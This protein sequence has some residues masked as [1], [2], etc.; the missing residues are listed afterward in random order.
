MLYRFLQ[1][2]F[3]IVFKI[4]FRVEVHN[5]ELIPDETKKLII[6]GNHTSNLDPIIMSAF[7]DRKINWM[8]KKELFNNKILAYFLKKLG[9]FPVDRHK[10]DLKA[11]KTALNIL[12]KDEVL[13]IFP[14]GTRVKEKNYD[15]IKAGVAL[16]AQ[17]TESEVLPFYI[18]GNFKIFRK[19]NIYY[20]E[21][22][23]IKKE[24]KYSNEELEEISQ[25]IM[26]LV[27]GDE[28]KWK[29]Y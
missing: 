19:I 7:F 28:I 26:R 4:I 8:G 9:V 18:D 17:R 20:R 16:I 6:C 29:L 21:P 5:K 23:K 22:I 24:I 11:V 14:E 1:V 15:S 13:G 27:Y 10:N 2:L 12:K 3:K 25:D